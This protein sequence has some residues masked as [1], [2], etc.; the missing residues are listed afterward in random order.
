MGGRPGHGEDVSLLALSH[1]AAV[2]WW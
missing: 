2:E 1:G